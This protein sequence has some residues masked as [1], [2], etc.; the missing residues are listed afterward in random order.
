MSCIFQVQVTTA[1]SHVQEVE[2]QIEE[3]LL[4]PYNNGSVSIATD[5]IHIRRICEW[6]I[7]YTGISTEDSRVALVQLS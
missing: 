3:L 1:P 7:V 4:V 6:G 5:D 2:Q